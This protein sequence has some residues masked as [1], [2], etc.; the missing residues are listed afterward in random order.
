MRRAAAE[1]AVTLA[2]LAIITAWIELRDPTSPTRLRVEEWRDDA[3]EW[4][5]RARANRLISKL[6]RSDPNAR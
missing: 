3:R 6:E 1:L 2:T 4:S 5:I